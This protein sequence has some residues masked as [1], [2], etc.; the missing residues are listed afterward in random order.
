MHKNAS[1]QTGAQPAPEP[2]GRAAASTVA[3][4][5]TGG[6]ALDV[7]TVSPTPSQGQT[8]ANRD[9]GPI[10]LSPSKAEKTCPN[11]PRSFSVLLCAPKRGT[12][13]PALTCS[14][15]EV[16]EMQDDDTFFKELRNH[17]R[18]L[19]GFW[20]YWFDIRQFSFCHASRFEKYYVDCLVW[21]RNEMPPDEE[22]YEYIPRPA[23]TPYEGILHE[24]EWQHRFQGLKTPGLQD[25]VKRVPK[26]N[27][28]FQLSTHVSR[29][30]LWGLHIQLRLCEDMVF[31][32]MVAITLGGGT[33]F[34]AL[35][36]GRHPGDLQN[37]SVPMSLSVSIVTLL[38]LLLNKLKD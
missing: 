25:V 18:I 2:S 29:E 13:R 24:H 37:A 10:P 33:V 31:A 9:P 3:T 15:I 14:I 21:R 36:L 38:C 28:R 6:P 22:T 1:E 27:C 34:M 23:L 5:D 32:W 16:S 4:T 7:A 20:H 26:R 19:R 35:W 17:Y 30:Y 8:D 12:R 11:L